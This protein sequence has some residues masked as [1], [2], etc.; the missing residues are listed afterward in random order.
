MP[1][2]LKCEIISDQLSN[3]THAEAC[4]IPAVLNTLWHG[5]DLCCV[6]IGFLL[7]TWP[8]AV[9]DASRANHHSKLPQGAL[10][11]GEQSSAWWP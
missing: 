1:Q 5:P 2:F 11:F 9:P 4:G 10:Y 3:F 7:A 6:L 8:S